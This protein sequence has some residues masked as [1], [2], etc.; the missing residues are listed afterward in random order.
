MG[1]ENF[2]NQM[3]KALSAFLVI[4]NKPKFKGLPCLLR[5]RGTHCSSS[6][7]IT[8]PVKKGWEQHGSSQA[9]CATGRSVIGIFGRVT[10]KERLH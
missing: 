4:S 1:R 8:F 10:E 6:C 5:A 2:E 3:L 9:A 7:F